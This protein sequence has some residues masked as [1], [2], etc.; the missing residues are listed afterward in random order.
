MQSVLVY[1][2]GA[3]SNDIALIKLATP[4]TYTQFIRP[5]CLPKRFEN[6]DFVDKVGSLTFTQKKKT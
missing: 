2:Y 3:F 5:A 1:R 6:E 4:V